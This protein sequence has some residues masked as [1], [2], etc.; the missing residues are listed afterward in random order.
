MTM[1]LVQPGSEP[2][3]RRMFVYRRDMH[4]EGEESL[5]RFVSPSDI[6]GIGLL[7][8]DH[9]GGE[10]DQWIY[11]P[12]LGRARRIASDRKGG[13]FVGSDFFYQ[14]LRNRK[15]SK[16]H[17]RLLGTQK[18]DGVECKVLQSVPVNPDTSVYS[19]VVSWIY[20]TALIPLRVDFYE[21]GRNKPIKRLTVH[22]LQKIQGYWTV[23]ESTMTDLRSGHYTRLTVQKAV[24]DQ[25]LPADLFTR[26]VLT[27]PTREMPYRP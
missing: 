21:S 16:D 9:P 14:D 6:A 1:T 23:M 7:T 15:V 19:K 3:V 17:H 25:N 12:A 4:G 8:V 10:T 13:R 27:D 22:K 5:I 20:P 26:K 2:R 11:L 18:L 24:Y